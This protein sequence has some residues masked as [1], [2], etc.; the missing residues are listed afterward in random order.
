VG[1]R[2]FSS[3]GFLAVWQG[4]PRPKS[5]VRSAFGGMYCSCICNIQRLH[6]RASKPFCYIEVAPSTTSR[7]HHEV[8]G[9]LM[10]PLRFLVPVLLLTSS[11]VLSAQDRS[12]GR[13]VV[14]T[15]FG[16]VATSEVQAS[17]AQ[18]TRSLQID[19]RLASHERSIGMP[20]SPSPHIRNGKHHGASHSYPM[21]ASCRFPDPSRLTST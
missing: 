15:P 18:T 5:Q 1:F 17:Q 9:G 3:A 13:S 4:Q 20:H 2:G 10:T 19:H 14:A 12:Y 7:L 21:S 6:T 16:F 8:T 11:T